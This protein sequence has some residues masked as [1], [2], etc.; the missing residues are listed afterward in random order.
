MQMPACGRCSLTS[1]HSDVTLADSHGQQ[2]RRHDAHSGTNLV[3]ACEK[4]KATSRND[5][6]TACSPTSQM[7]CGPN[8]AVLHAAK[9]L[10]MADVC[11]VCVGPALL[12]DHSLTA[13]SKVS[14]LT[15]LQS[16]TGSQA[17]TQHADNS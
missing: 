16:T 7:G 17:R 14:P 10:K 13:T 9:L 6:P 8:Y 3:K 4:A 15:H 12:T 5:L 1:A 2:V 11:A